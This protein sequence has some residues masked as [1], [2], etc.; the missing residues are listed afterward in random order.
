MQLFQA[1]VKIGIVCI[2]ADDIKSL[3]KQI[4]KLHRTSDGMWKK[5]LELWTTR[6]DRLAT[7][8]MFF[9]GL[10]T[11]A[12]SSAPIVWYLLTQNRILIINMRLPYLDVNTL[13]GFIGVSIF[14]SI[15]F[16]VAVIVTYA[17]DLLFVTYCFSGAAYL[18]L[19]RLDCEE[20]ANRIYAMSSTEYKS[21]V[22]GMLNHLIV[23]SREMKK[24]IAQ[25]CLF[26][27][28]K[29]LVFH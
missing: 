4:Q 12:T 8:Q 29:P 3:H 14:G 18:D 7:I 13:N 11:F 16:N 20:F 24:Y 5:P 25:L 1:L 17:V 2:F 15:A 19:I 28:V 6:I 21:K 27:Y 23:R 22:P 9:Y 10:A 26:Y